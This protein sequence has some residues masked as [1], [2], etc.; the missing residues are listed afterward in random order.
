MARV[1]QRVLE[2]GHYVAPDTIKGV[3]QKNLQH[4]NE[5]RATFKVIELYDGMKRPALLARTEDNEVTMA[6]DLSLKKTWLKQG[7][8]DIAAKINVF[9]AGEK[10]GS[11]HKPK[12]EK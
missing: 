12:Q 10:A 9:N 3:Y 1:G 7:L 4:I 8:P 11:K 6:T 5:F 2:G